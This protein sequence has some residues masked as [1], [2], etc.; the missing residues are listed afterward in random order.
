[1]HFTSILAVLVAGS[2]DLAACVPAPIV[3][4]R[5]DLEPYQPYSV[6][7][8]A[9][10]LVRP[11]ATINPHEASY[12]RKRRPLADAALRKWLQKTWDS[13]VDVSSCELPAVA[14]SLG[15][16]GPKAGLLAAGVLQAL[17]SRDSSSD[18]SGLLQSMTYMSA[19]SGGSLTL[20]GVLAN[21]FG[22]ISTL[23]TTLWDTTY[24]N[25]LAVPLANVA[26]IVSHVSQNWPLQY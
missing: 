25:V 2:A 26:Q 13:K 9:G 18:V 10:N 1:M 8:P 11:A 3:A 19:L 17:D 14:L 21:N 16:G 23:R 6:S 12:I 24:Q 15:G 5:S 20:D 22:K 7:C 4:Q